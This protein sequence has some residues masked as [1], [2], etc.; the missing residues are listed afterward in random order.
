MNGFSV[1]MLAVVGMIVGIMLGNYLHDKTTESTQTVANR[2]IHQ[3]VVDGREC[4][5]LTQLGGKIIALDCDWSD[6]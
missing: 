4:M 6:K 3:V 1:V 5:V 2:R